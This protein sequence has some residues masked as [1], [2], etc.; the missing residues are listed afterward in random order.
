MIRVLILLP[1]LAA[2]GWWVEREQSAGHLRQVDEL[3]L[4]FLTGNARDRFEKAPA[5]S[6]A[7]PPVVWVRMR[8]AEKAEYGGWPPHPLDWQMVFKGLQPFEPAVI[9]IPEV[10]TWGRPSPEFVREAS[11]ALMPFPSTVLGVEG[12]LAAE[13]GAPAFLGGL[14]EVLPRFQKVAGDRAA[15]PVLGALIAAPDEQLRRRAEIGIVIVPGSR[16]AQAER[17]LPYALQEG[18]SLRPSLFAQAM[19]RVSGT[20]YALHRVVFGPGAGAYLADG[21]FVPL[22]ETGSFAVDPQT[23]VP[24]VNALNLMTAELAEALTAEDKQRLGRGRVV[25]I[26]TDDGA[27]GSQAQAHAQALARALAMPRI[28]ALPQWAEW[29]VWGLAAVMGCA[30]VSLTPRRKALLRGALLIFLGLVACF[31]AFQ[32]WLVW[33]PPTL[34]VALLVAATLF[35]RVAGK[36]AKRERA[37]TPPPPE[38][39]L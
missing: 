34:P 39:G 1:L 3:F 29:G 8:A 25:V 23:A 10:L 5:A 28:Q 2:L 27:L 37:P 18:S 15:A 6:T 30:L 17:L 24:E 4:D 26:G 13:P 19:A 20:P 38:A 16:K 12:T 31:L 9:V 22:T 21:G 14:E 7:A 36:P 33:C 35:A 11:Q 32:V